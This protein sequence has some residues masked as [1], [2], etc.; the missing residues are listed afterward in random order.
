VRQ[1]EVVGWDAAHAKDVQCRQHCALQ[2]VPLAAWLDHV[3]AVHMLPRAKGHMQ[4]TSTRGRC[5]RSAA[6]ASRPRIR[7]EA[8]INKT[9]TLVNEFE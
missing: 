2:A 4:A 7:V 6:L 1:P 8:L 5:A 9:E 3:G